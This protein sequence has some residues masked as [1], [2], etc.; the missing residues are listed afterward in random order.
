MKTINLAHSPDADDIFMYMA[1]KFGWVRNFNYQNKALDIQSLNDFALQNEF[2]V[3]AISFGVYPLIA[4]EYALLRTAV[5]FG[6]GYGPKLIKK[7]NTTLK[8]NFKVA[9]SGAN[10]TNALLFRMKYKDARIVYK[11]FLDI[12]KAVLSGE[13]DAGVLIHESILDFDENL[14][15]ETEIWDLWLEFAKE[16][17]PLPLGGM[18]LRRSLPISDAILIE[19]DLTKAVDLAHN[20]KKI[21]SKMLFERN[22][23]RVNA[24]NLDTYLNL[25]ANKNS[26]SM[27]EE[28][29]LALNIL[30]KLGYEYKF[31]DKIINVE[32]YLIPCEYENARYS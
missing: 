16:Q 28:Q 25:Y 1:I 2:D 32:N 24:T 14:C 4:K 15:V 31:Y 12:E 18:A 6:Q 17:I 22:L 19:K 29:L 3:S 10:T 5:S 26:I 23:I 11:N 7:K 9:L 20:N 27:N 30:F 13:V 8:K 21:M